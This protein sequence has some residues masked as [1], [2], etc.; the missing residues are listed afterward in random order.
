MSDGQ[1]TGAND[2]AQNILSQISTLI[3][4]SPGNVSFNTVYYGTGDAT[5]AGLLREMSVRGKGNFL[6]TNA[7]PSGLDFNISDLINVP[8]P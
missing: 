6:N 8:C 7:N 1:P 3:G 2:L 5:A 4:L